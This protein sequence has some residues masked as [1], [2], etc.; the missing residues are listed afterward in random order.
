MSMSNELSTAKSL[1]AL[2]VYFYASQRYGVDLPQQ[3]AEYRRLIEA[4][5]AS[6]TALKNGPVGL[7]TTRSSAAQQAEQQ[8]LLE[9]RQVTAKAR[10]AFIAEHPLVARYADVEAS[11]SSWKIQ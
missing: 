6:Y 1:D 2:A 8:G 5:E 4:D 7:S 10:L 3:L 11:V 9:A